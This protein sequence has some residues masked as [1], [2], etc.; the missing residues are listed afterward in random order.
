MEVFGNINCNL[1]HCNKCLDSGYAWVTSCS[2]IFCNEDGEKLFQDVLICPIC[3]KELDSKSELVRIQLKP[4]EHYRNMIL[5]GQRP[6][7]ILDICNKGLSFWFAQIKQQN[8]Y[9][10][11]I[12]EKEREKRLNSENC[13]SNSLF[14]I[15]QMQSK[16]DELKRENE[17]LKKIICEKFS[18]LQKQNTNQNLVDINNNNNNNNTNQMLRMVSSSEKSNEINN[19]IS[20][21][22]F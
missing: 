14:L 7:V 5:C 9:M 11:H 1:K 20:R 22:L 17:M 13:E 6:E 19:I 3:M 16:Q 4:T 15:K 8:D 10:K 18:A 12:V 2:H 21:N